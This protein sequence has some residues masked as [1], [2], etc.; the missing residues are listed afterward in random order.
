M[1]RHKLSP[2]WNGP[3]R[4]LSRLDLSTGDIG[5]T[6]KVLDLLDPRS[7]PKV[8]HYNRL[9][10]YRSVWSPEPSPVLRTPQSGRPPLTGLSGSRPYVHHDSSVPKSVRPIQGVQERDGT[11][12][13]VQNE[14]SEGSRAELPVEI[15]CDR[16]AEGTKTRSGRSVRPPIRYR[17]F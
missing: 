1:S 5:V 3:Y 8:I 17:D 16:P 6:Y 11:L 4:V 13:P 2:K 9:K 7:K 14:L 15:P 10:P 12:P